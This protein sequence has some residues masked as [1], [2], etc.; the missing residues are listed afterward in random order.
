M[1]TYLVIG[2]FFF[3]GAQVCMFISAYHSWVLIDEVNELLP[4]NE[5]FPFAWWD[6]IKYWRFSKARKRVLPDSPRHKKMVLFAAIGFGLF[7][8]SI[9]FFLSGSLW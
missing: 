6:P 7:L 9:A 3:V 1:T 2:A 8:V 4:E 5:R